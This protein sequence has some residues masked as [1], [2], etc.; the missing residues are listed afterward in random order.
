MRHGICSSIMAD[1][2]EN[3]EFVTVF[4]KKDLVNND[5]SLFAEVISKPQY[6]KKFSFEFSLITTLSRF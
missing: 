1:E 3:A 4:I 2:G 6:A 5:Y